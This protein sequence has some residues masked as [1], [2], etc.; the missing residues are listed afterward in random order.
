M[1][2]DKAP[3][4]TA[5]ILTAFDAI[6]AEAVK[7][8]GVLNTTPLGIVNREDAARLKRTAVHIREQAQAILDWI[9]EE[10][11]E[12]RGERLRDA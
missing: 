10:R 6:V 7:V 4:P 12:L 9:G 11:L 1:R 2:T 3:N 8:E 5:L